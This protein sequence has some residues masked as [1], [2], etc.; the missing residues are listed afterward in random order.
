MRDPDDFCP[1]VRLEANRSANAVAVKLQIKPSASISCQ[2]R[3]LIAASFVSNEL[4][5]RHLK[6]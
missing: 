1:L 4:D 6:A 2:L 5:N 3:R